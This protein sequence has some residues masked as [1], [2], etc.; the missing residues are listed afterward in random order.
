M[1]QI[2]KQLPA[3]L[4]EGSW[5]L[6]QPVGCRL[7]MLDIQ[8]VWLNQRYNFKRF[9]TMYTR[10]GS[11]GERV[12]RITCTHRHSPST[13]HAQTALSGC[14]I[15]RRCVPYCC[16]ST[17]YVS[18]EALSFAEY[19]TPLPVHS[20]RTKPRQPL[21]VTS[22]LPA[23]STDAEKYVKH[24]AFAERRRE[25]WPWLESFEHTMAEKTP[26]RFFFSW[27][28]L[29]LKTEGTTNYLAIHLFLEIPSLAR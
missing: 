12:D 18:L 8:R 29:R 26:N 15:T 4:F 27:P 10:D 21:L 16:T 2:T 17:D 14:T 23:G 25:T 20:R 6:Q 22:R 5:V 24:V 1:L 13:Y 3:Q 28:G 11:E 19:T 9:C 7:Q